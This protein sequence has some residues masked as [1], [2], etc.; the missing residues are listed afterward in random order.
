MPR[1][2]LI[3][4]ANGRPQGGITA[5][6]SDEPSFAVTTGGPKHP[7]RAL[8]SQGSVVAMTPRALA[9]FQTFPDWY[10]LPESRSL[11]ALGIGNAAPPLLMQKIYETLVEAN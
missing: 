10:E 7:Q 6:E 1:A 5:R 4:G 9:R 3:D 11:A 8:L 2:F